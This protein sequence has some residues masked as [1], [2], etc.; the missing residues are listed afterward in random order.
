MFLR[1]VTSY[2]RGCTGNKDPKASK[3]IICLVELVIIAIEFLVEKPTP[4]R[5]DLI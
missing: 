5:P 3:V 4:I 1:K 2:I